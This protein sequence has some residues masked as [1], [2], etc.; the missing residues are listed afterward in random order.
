[1]NRLGRGSDDL[2]D[3][4]V[5]G[6]ALRAAPHGAGGSAPALLADVLGVCFWHREII[7]RTGL[8]IE[9]DDQLED[10]CF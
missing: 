8:L 7:S 2:L 10:E 4:A 6:T 1:M 3:H 5:P 9:K